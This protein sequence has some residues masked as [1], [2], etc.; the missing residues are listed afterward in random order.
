VN[1]L[2]LAA[3]PAIDDDYAGQLAELVERNEPLDDEAKRVLAK[4][5]ERDNPFPEINYREF[6]A[7]Q[8]GAELG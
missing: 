8:G 6:A 4:I 3:V 5:R 2:T 1:A 7:R